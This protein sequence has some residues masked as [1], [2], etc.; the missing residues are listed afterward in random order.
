M[1]EEQDAEAVEGLD[2]IQV[3]SVLM[4]QRL[5]LAE[6]QVLLVWKLVQGL[7]LTRPFQG[8]G[9]LVLFAQLL[10]WQVSL[11]RFWMRRTAGPL[12]V[13]RPAWQENLQVP[14]ADLLA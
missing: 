6:T 7:A 5:S 9:H 8:W 12:L 1:A 13:L 11:Q 3:D 10:V 4:P 14:L 2:A